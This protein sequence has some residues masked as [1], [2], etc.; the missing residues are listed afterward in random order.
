MKNKILSTMNTTKKK[1]GAVLLCGALVATIGAG[2]AF[3]ANPETSI[4]SK[5]EN[6]VR[7]Y[8][9][10]GGQTW[11]ENVP[12]DM[13]V[14]NGREGTVMRG[15][16]TN[17]AGYMVKTK[18]GAGYMVKIENGTKLYSTDGGETWS[19][20]V[21][22][23]MPEFNGKEGNVMRMR[24]M[25]PDG[26]AGYMVKVENGT[27]L[28]SVDGGETWSED[29]PEGMPEFNGKEGNVMRMRGMGPDGGAGYMVKVEN[30]TKLYSVDGGETWSEDVPEGMPEF[31][32]KEGNV[33]RMRGM[34]P[35]GGAGYMVKVENGTKLYSADGGE[36]WS[37]DVPEGMPEFNGKEGNVM[38]MRGMGPDG[39]TGYTVKIENGIKLYSTDGGETWSE[40][41]PDGWN[42]NVPGGMNIKKK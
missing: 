14:F 17:G 4:L 34:G 40:D 1:A 30:G 23:G 32:G 27:K 19:E 21:P 5:I 20:D 8:S 22:E 24:G 12:A 31:N 7:A 37:E 26:G 10:D 33:M 28:Y 15:M 36:T 29:V 25:G 11:S 13:P 3:A 2:T 6:G 38:R 41:A 18:D 16:E 42:E 9:T 39:G 35:D